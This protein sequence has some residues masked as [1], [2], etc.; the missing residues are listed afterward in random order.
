VGIVTIY[1]PPLSVHSRHGGVASYSKNL[2]SSLLKYCSVTVFA[3]KLST[4]K[5]RHH[6]AESIH[7]CWTKGIKYP[8][9]I[10]KTILK[11]EVDVFHIQ[12]ETYLFG[13]LASGLI[14]PLLVA[15]IGLLRKPVIVTMHGVIPLSR[16]NSSFLRENRIQGNTLIMRIG[17]TFLVRLIV[18][19]STAVIVHEENLSEILKKE[20]NIDASKINVINHG[21]EEPKVMINSNEAKEKLG[22]H[23]KKVI[24]FL[25]YITGYK[26][27][28]LLIDSAKFLKVDNWVILIAGGMHPRLM[29]DINYVKYV[30]ELRKRAMRISEQN[31]LFKGFVPEEEI[32]SY[33]SAADL[34]VFPYNICISSSGPL[35]LAASYE[36]PFLAT[37]SFREIITLDEIRFINE[38]EKLAAKI[39]CFFDDSRL[40]LR[41]L[42][43]VQKFKM[44]RSWT[45]IA[46]KT[47]LLYKKLAAT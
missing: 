26:N 47:Y 43:W 38:P 42:D 31:I 25:G 18:F 27:V 19:L 12:Y 17:L 32:C 23:S 5:G 28:G 46:K 21:V 41:I 40:R 29:N 14:F 44:K 33:L 37:N 45:K 24:L 13:G 34:V 30:S 22:V 3:E 11:N 1:P 9:Q 36:K 39:N 10:F 8:F 15:L 35:S 2:V 6:E 7:R 4:S 20:Y 16:L